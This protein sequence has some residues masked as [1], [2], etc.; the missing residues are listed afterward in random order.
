[1]PLSPKRICNRCGQATRGRCECAPKVMEQRKSARERGYTTQWDKA[2]KGFLS[3]H[4]ICSE[5]Q[6]HKR[7]VPATVVDHKLP[8]KGDMELFW[9]SE[10][11]QPLCSLCHARKTDREKRTM[12][13]YVVCGPPG[14]GKTTWVKA[15]ANQGDLVFD[16]DYLLKTL[17]SSELHASIEYAMPLVE[18]LREMV[19]DWLLQYPDRHAYVI[20]AEPVAARQTAARLGAEVVEL[21]R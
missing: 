1:M 19:V 9:I 7:I 4:P 2:R 3:R 8:H 16:A 18:R 13:K 15:R 20:Q 6:W 14:S 12:S 21:E 5:C 11:W 17:F 10:W